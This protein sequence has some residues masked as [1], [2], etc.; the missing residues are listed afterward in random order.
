MLFPKLMGVVNVTP[1]SFSDN[2]IFADTQAAIDHARKLIDEGANIIDIGGESTRPGATPITAQEEMDRVLPVIEKLRGALISIDTYHPETMREAVK[3]GAGMINDIY[4]LR[5]PGALEAAASLDVPVC[6]MH[7]QGDPPTM[8]DAPAYNNVVDE[9]IQFLQAAMI[10]AKSFGIPHDR[11]I[12]DPGIGFGKTD[13]HNIA[14]L[15]A[16]P[17]LAELGPTLIGVSRKGFIG[18]LSG[19]ASVDDR[20]PGSVA[21]ALYAWQQGASILRVHDVRATRNALIVFDALQN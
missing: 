12:L 1:D 4:A 11:L 19:G 21:A 10:S 17:R 18:R 16:L 15:R 5:K 2:G 6:L 8:Q 9:V 14:L 7:M 3:A 20:L 13:A